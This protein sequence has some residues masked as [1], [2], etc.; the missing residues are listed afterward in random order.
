MIPQ[1]GRDILRDES[2]AALLLS[3]SLVGARGGCL[4]CC[5]YLS[6]ALLTAVANGSAERTEKCTCSL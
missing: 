1:R 6:S 5:P 4:P 3:P 2:V